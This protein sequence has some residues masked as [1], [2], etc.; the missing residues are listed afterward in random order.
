MSRKGAKAAAPA[1][2]ERF[3][4]DEIV[5]GAVVFM[6]S[7]IIEKEMADK[8]NTPVYS[9]DRLKAVSGPFNFMCVHRSEKTGR[10]F[11]TP[12]ERKTDHR[13]MVDG[14]RL[15]GA[16]AFKSGSHN[17][18][19]GQ[20]WV[21][22]DEVVNLAS[23]GKDYSRKGGRNYV[24]PPYPLETFDP[25]ALRWQ[26]VADGKKKEE[27][28]VAA[29]DPTNGNALF[30]GWNKDQI[31]AQNATMQ[32]Q[33]KAI[34]GEILELYPS[35]EGY[36][37]EDLLR[38]SETKKALD[39]MVAPTANNTNLIIRMGAQTKDVIF[40]QHNGGPWIPTLRVLHRYPWMMASH[41]V[42]IGGCKFVISGADVM[43]PGVTS[44]GGRVCDGVEV[45]MPVALFIEGKNTAAAVGIALMSSQEIR[46]KN[47][48][49]C[50]QTIHFLGDGLWTGGSL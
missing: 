24:T 5:P 26:K 44:K 25:V 43:C 1:E 37:N 36:L 42:D 27:V 20:L 49:R 19:T 2:G 38:D 3:S 50:V 30:K 13:T 29:R 28:V 48:D 47:K 46:D 41:Q 23:A 22:D 16:P 33:Q 21:L 40:F 39:I 45:G 35:L 34:K 10:S 15:K 8:V 18:H 11:W 32:K 12:L 31:T 6:D 4:A 14:D 17:F 7:C 9:C